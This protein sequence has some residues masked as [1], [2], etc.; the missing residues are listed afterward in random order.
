MPNQS[1][2][3]KNYDDGQ[4]QFI[5]LTSGDDLLAHTYEIKADDFDS[6]HLMVL[7][8]VRLIYTMSESGKSGVALI[9]WVMGHIVPDQSFKIYTNDV[10]TTGIPSKGLIK[11]YDTFLEEFEKM[12][13]KHSNTDNELELTEE[14]K[15]F[16]HDPYDDDG[17]IEVSEEGNNKEEPL[18]E[19]EYTDE[20]L[21]RFDKITREFYQHRKKTIN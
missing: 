6:D 15:P 5:R 13:T 2:D 4:V 11:Y 14:Q 21:R 9:P 10:L 17:E 3:V 19:E 7:N 18:A 1:T 20:N 16:L 12:L 8:P